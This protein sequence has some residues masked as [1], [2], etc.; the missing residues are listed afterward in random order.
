MTHES[1]F[2]RCPVKNME[3]RK[4]MDVSSFLLFEASGDSEQLESDPGM[5]VS[6]HGIDVDKDDAE[7][8]SCD[9]SE[10]VVQIDEFDGFD[11]EGYDDYCDVEE[12]EEEEDGNDQTWTSKPVGPQRFAVGL[13]SGDRKSSVCVDSTEGEGKEMEK[14]RLFWEACLAS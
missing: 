2:F 1:N 12:E 7:S 13:T 11:A 10:S 3:S 8:C 4:L 9:L 14:S 5:A 6:E